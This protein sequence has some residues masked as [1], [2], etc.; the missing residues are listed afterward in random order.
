MVVLWL[1]PGAT[2]KIVPEETSRC[3]A[4]SHMQI[5]QEWETLYRERPSLQCQYLDEVRSV[6]FCIEPD[7][8][9]DDSE[10]D[11]YDRRGL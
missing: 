5:I 9:C 6:G 4:G 11:G 2:Q 10:G 7:D 3:F 1:W 8:G